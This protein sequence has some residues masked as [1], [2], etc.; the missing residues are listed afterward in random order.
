[1]YL[2]RLLSAYCV[3]GTDLKDVVVNRKDKNAC[4]PKAY[5]WKR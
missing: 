3:L 5:I 4:S 2:S 1:M